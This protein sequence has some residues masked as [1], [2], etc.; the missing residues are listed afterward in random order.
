MSNQIC[1][2]CIYIPVQRDIDV[3]KERTQKVAASRMYVLGMYVHTYIFRCFLLCR[4]T[5]LTS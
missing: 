2:Y 5:S 3:I 4:I 1:M